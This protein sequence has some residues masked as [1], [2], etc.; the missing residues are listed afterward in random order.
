L[1]LNLLGIPL[2]FTLFGLTLAGVA[3]F[4]RA[5]LQISLAGLAAILAY[6]FA[7][8]GFPQG[9]G[10]AGFT[11]HMAHEWVL[12]ANLFLL[13]LGFA[14]LANQFERS[15]APEVIPGL[16]P[17][18][19]TGGLCLLGFIFLL[20]TIL[21]NIAGA[22]VGGV[23]A[24]HAY[25]DKVG[26]GFLAA[27]VAAANAGGAGSVIGDTTTTMLWIGG[28]SAMAVAPAFIG[29]GAAF[30]VFGVAAA[31]QQHR[32]Q[33]IQ[34][35]I[36]APVSVN[37][38]RL[39]TVLAMLV[40]LV[41]TNVFVS[42]WAPQ[43]EHVVP[44]IGL[45]LW[46]AILVTSL[47]RKPNWP[48]LIPAA[49]GAVFLLA[50]VGAAS[51]MPVESLPTPTWQ[52]TLGIGAIAAVFDNIPLTALALQQGGYD[53]ALLAYAVGVGG[54][55]LW[56]GSSAGVALT[57]LFPEGRSS[58]RWVKEGWH[59][60]LAYFVGFFTLLVVCGWTTAM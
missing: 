45:G 30:A 38:G 5:A 41:A 3:I 29:A 59:V 55:S 15:N 35:H 8:T 4:H 10:L 44:A 54:S 49:K 36:G 42:G 7:V 46:G 12:L 18:N 24:R 52:S 21:D 1:G 58:L 26:V 9:P 48:V 51:L 57:N 43:L 11:A 2:E 27:I 13:L 16:L 23:V 28:V 60:V 33:P 6:K 22:V 39:G 37:W 25:R 56:F 40:A 53:W 19:W 31:L 14:I 47:L 34:P 32:L 50:L 17:R 20:S